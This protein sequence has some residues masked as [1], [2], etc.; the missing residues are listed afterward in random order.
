MEERPGGLGIPRIRVFVKRYRRLVKVGKV[1]NNRGLS[2]IL[3]FALIGSGYLPYRH[4]TCRRT[5]GV[6]VYH[7]S[8][9]TI[10]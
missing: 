10:L 9:R 6:G 5:E 8:S 2:E 3:G 1:Y 4:V 7:R